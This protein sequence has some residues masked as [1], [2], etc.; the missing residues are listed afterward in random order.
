MSQRYHN[1]K[2]IFITFEIKTKRNTIKRNETLT[3]SFASAITLRETKT[4]LFRKQ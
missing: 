3:F 4:I 2:I 1:R